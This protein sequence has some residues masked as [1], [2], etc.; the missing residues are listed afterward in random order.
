MHQVVRRVDLLPGPQPAQQ[1]LAGAY[2]PAPLAAEDGDGARAGE[3]RS[4]RV[5]RRDVAQVLGRE[6]VAPMQQ[7]LRIGLL[8]RRV[9]R[10]GVGAAL[11]RAACEPLAHERLAVCQVVGLEQRAVDAHAEPRVGRRV[12]VP[13]PP[14]DVLEQ[15]HGADVAGAP[16]GEQLLRRVAVHDALARQRG[17]AVARRIGRRRGPRG[18]A[19]HV[20]QVAL[21]DHAVALRAPGLRQAPG[22][23]GEIA[24]HRLAHAAAEVAHA[25][26]AHD[27]GTERLRRARDGVA[28][29][30]VAQVTDVQRLRRVG[31]AEVDDPAAAGG[32]GA[33]RERVRLAALQGSAEARHLP[34]GEA[35]A[36]RLARSRKRRQRA[37][38]ARRVRPSGIPP[39]QA[40]V[41]GSGSK[42]DDRHQRVV[43]A[44]RGDA[45]VQAVEQ[46]RRR[47]AEAVA[48]HGMHQAGLEPASTAF[49]A[50]P[51]TH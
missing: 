38:A 19:A 37:T 41:D 7:Q 39:L 18:Q 31:I 40:H 9:H 1:R 47:F 45:V 49:K 16:A 23:I 13:D 11:D 26:L 35:D 6:A 8:S 27:V 44:E 17:V 33:G 34:V 42:R 48:S 36:E 43:A 20:A 46:V 3:Q 51:L 29:R 21:A 2:Q 50:G 32:D 24:R 14:A 15:A 5:V 4:R 30:D 25:T 10:R 22:A 28:D 12:P